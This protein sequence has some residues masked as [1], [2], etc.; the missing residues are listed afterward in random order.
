ME[1]EKD[2]GVRHHSVNESLAVEDE[3]T[4]NTAGFPTKVKVSASALFGSNKEQ[5]R[6]VDLTSSTR[7][8]PDSSGNSSNANLIQ[9]TT[10]A[11]KASAACKIL[12][13]SQS[14]ENADCD[15]TT[16]T[17]SKSSIANPGYRFR[18]PGSSKETAKSSQSTSI[19][20]HKLKET[21]CKLAAPSTKRPATSSDY[22]KHSKKSKSSESEVKCHTEHIPPATAASVEY[23]GIEACPGM[24]NSVQTHTDINPKCSPE[25]PHSTSQGSIRSERKN[26]ANQPS[27]DSVSKPTKRAAVGE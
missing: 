4:S 24:L 11:H 16:S 6:R 25:A 10:A 14:E 13:N 18:R 7:V 22:T 27:C 26:P 8:H 20:I 3:S 21:Q 19:A 9:K 23:G 12:G 5:L 17:K 15:V 1:T 2:T